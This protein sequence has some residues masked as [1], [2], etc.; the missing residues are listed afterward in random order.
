MAPKMSTYYSP[1]PMTMLPYLAKK[2]IK[3][4]CGLKD[5]IILNYVDGL[6]VLKSGDTFLAVVRESYNERRVRD[7][8]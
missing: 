1:R 2:K 7:T 3:S 8:L 6:R 5:E 4:H